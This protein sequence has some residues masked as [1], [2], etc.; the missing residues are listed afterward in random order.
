MSKFC[1]PNV[2]DKCSFEELAVLY[3][4][5]KLYSYFYHIP[6][7]SPLYKYK[8]EFLEVSR[9]KSISVFYLQLTREYIDKRPP[10]TN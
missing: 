3:E 6:E 5:S 8:E 7:S 4:E 1:Y 9:Y 10:L 2:F